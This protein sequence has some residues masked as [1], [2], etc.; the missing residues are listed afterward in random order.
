MKW[1]FWSR[2]K[3]GQ[4]S[5]RKNLSDE[6]HEVQRAKTLAA[7]TMNSLWGKKD[8]DKV[9]LPVSTVRRLAQATLKLKAK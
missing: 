6:E 3:E 2:N 1:Q 8:T 7:D 5:D 9:T 4:F